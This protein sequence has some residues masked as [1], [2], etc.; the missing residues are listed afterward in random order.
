[1]LSTGDPVRHCT[2]NAVCHSISRIGKSHFQYTLTG[3][4]VASKQ[5][6]KYVTYTAPTL[7][8]WDIHLQM[9]SNT[10]TKRWAT[11]CPFSC[12]SGWQY[13]ADHDREQTDSLVLLNLA[14]EPDSLN[15]SPWWAAAVA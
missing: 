5:Y 10:T 7:Q 6:R 12:K 14:A 9:L 1:M 2:G 3:I 11:P 8:K 13:Q 4:A 15:H